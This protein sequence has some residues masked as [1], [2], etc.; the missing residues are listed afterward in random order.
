M[1][2][3]PL[4]VQYR[5]F[6]W[7][8]FQDP[9][10][11]VTGDKPETGI[12]GSGTNQNLSKAIHPVYTITNILNK[13]RILDGTKVT[14]SSWVRLFKLHARGYKVLSHIEDTTVPPAETDPTYEA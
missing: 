12:G 5:F 9:I 1:V 13:V 3:E 8:F 10:I 4:K 2:L 11:M 7:P 14:Y 6:F